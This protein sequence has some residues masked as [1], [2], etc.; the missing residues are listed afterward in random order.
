MVVAGMVKLKVADEGNTLAER[1]T[2]VEFPG[3]N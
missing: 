2:E 1:I 3:V